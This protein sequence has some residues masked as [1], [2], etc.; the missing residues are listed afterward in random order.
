MFSFYSLDESSLKGYKLLFD[1]LSLIPISHYLIALFVSLLTFLYNF[2]EFHF[3]R[4]LFSGFRGSPVGLT[5]NPSSSAL[6]DGVVS[7]CRVLH[8][9]YLP[10]PWLSSP[11]IQTGF[12]HFFG[13]PPSLSYTRQLFHL[14]DGGII[15][16][17][18]LMSSNGN[19][20]N[21]FGI[22]SYFH[23]VLYP[24]QDAYA[25]KLWH[26]TVVATMKHFFGGSFSMSNAIS[27][28]DTTPIVLV[29]PG[30]TSD[31]SSAYIKHLAF[32]MA[33]RGWNVVVSNHRGLGGVS[34]TSDCFYNAGWTEDMREVVNYL[35]HEYLKA[36]LFTVGTS[37]GANILVKYLGEDGENS[38]V[39]GAVAICSP[40]DLL[41][42]DRFICRRM[43]QKFYDRALAFG[44]V[45]YAQLHEPRYSRLANWEGIRTNNL[46][47][48]VRHLHYVLLIVYKFV[49]PTN[50]CLS[51]LCFN[52]HVLFEI[53]TTYATCL[54]GKF[55]TVDTYYR[56]CSSS[57]YIGKVSVPLLCVS[58]LDD[59]VCT[60]E[61]IP[62]DECRANKN[63]VLATTHHGGHLAF[64]EGITANGVWWVR[65][66]DEFL[67]VLHSS[68]YMHVQKKMEKSGLHSSIESS[69]DQGP[70][71][72]VSADGMVAAVGNEKTRNSMFGDLPE[73]RKMYHNVDNET[74]PNAEQDEQCTAAKSDAL[75]TIVLT[76]E[77]PTNIPDVKIPNITASV[78]R[79]LNWLPQ[80]SRISVWLLAYIAIVTTWPLVGS[81]IGII[82]R[83]KHKNVPPAALARR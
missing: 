60:R 66:V 59:P 37:I 81:A 26:L 65:A 83:K 68:P 40:W 56:R 82:F 38:P 32:H 21:L 46:L 67:S 49:L 7:K 13:R 36:P 8:G 57:S 71:V 41:I 42:G 61:A 19:Y 34:I 35:H 52:S 28:D 29:I 75:P 74:V 70:Y 54:V 58:A 62:W 24:V 55:E 77:Q 23:I 20:I 51:L 33:K 78:N 6:Y 14:S 47:K 72:N 63:V 22:G 45:G 39:A 44:L 43:V 69:I 11:H 31:S 53:L 27:K 9:R 25:M 79:Y 10:T 1:A 76:S 30:L 64:F 16:L 2:L 17:D 73:S 80:S 50:C 15:A 4:D 48:L 3:F 12:L 18:W 5:F